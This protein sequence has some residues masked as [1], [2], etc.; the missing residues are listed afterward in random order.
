MKRFAAHYLHLQ[1]FGFLKQY[2]VEMEGV[3]AVRVFPL[4]EEI[5][6]VEWMPGV[7]AL[8][9]KEDE[10]G[11]NQD[12]FGNRPN[13]VADEIMLRP[14]ELNAWLLYPF[15]FISMRPVAGTQRKQL[16]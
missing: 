7:I 6:C 13:R 15:D 1:E 12:L 16:R 8:T 9:S 14:H 10:I 4:T 5:E 11:V 2:V 3:Y